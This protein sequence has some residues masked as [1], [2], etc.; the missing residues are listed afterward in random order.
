MRRA[1]SSLRTHNQSYSHPGDVGTTS[2]L[3]Y[4]LTPNYLRN[5]IVAWLSR[6][7][8]IQIRQLQFIVCSPD[9][10]KTWHCLRL[11]ALRLSSLTRTWRRCFIAS[12][13]E[14]SANC[15]KQEDVGCLP[16]SSNKGPNVGM[17]LHDV[18]SLAG[19]HLRPNPFQP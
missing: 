11:L 9:Y 16:P 8:G 18:D 13:L 19:Q 1:S 5:E 2:S 15:G 4:T 12:R 14:M 3:G 6:L 7:L 10:Y 17:E